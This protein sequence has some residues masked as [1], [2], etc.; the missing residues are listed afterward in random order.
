MPLPR[1]LRGGKFFW[2]NRKGAKDVKKRKGKQEGRLN[3]NFSLRVSFSVP[4][5]L[6]LLSSEERKEGRK[7]PTSKAVRPS[8]RSSIFIAPERREHKKKQKEKECGSDDHFFA[9]P[10]RALRLNK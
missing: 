5:S 4:A 7:L 3:Y 10:L 6:W 1:R 9:F 8:L 2:F